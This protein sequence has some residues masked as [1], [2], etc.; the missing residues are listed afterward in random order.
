M[1]EKND[2]LK[3]SISGGR[4]NAEDHPRVFQGLPTAVNV[5]GAQYEGRRHIRAGQ[6]SGTAV[7]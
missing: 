4:E 6:P 2:S 3:P 1:L 5:Y 7:T